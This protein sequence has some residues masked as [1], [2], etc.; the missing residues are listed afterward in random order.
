LGGLFP[1][2]ARLT[3]SNRK[4]PVMK[5]DIVNGPGRRRKRVSTRVVELGNNEVMNDP[6]TPFIGRNFRCGL[7]KKEKD[8]GEMTIVGTV[9]MFNESEASD[10]NRLKVKNFKESQERDRCYLKES[11]KTMRVIQKRSKKMSMLHNSLYRMNEGKKDVSV[12]VES[13]KDD[14]WLKKKLDHS[15]ILV[16]DSQPANHGWSK[17][18]DELSSMDQGLDTSELMLN[19]EKIKVDNAESSGNKFYV[20]QAYLINSLYRVEDM[21]MANHNMNYGDIKSQIKQKFSVKSPRTVSISKIDKLVSRDNISGSQ[22]GDD[23]RLTA[24]IDQD[25]SSM[26]P[27]LKLG[28]NL[29]TTLQMQENTSGKYSKNRSHVSIGGRSTKLENSK[30]GVS[31]T[32]MTVFQHDETRHNSNSHVGPDRRRDCGK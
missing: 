5:T 28:R 14:E 30:G 7:I 23:S 24:A 31:M 27:S 17:A 32:N 20:D 3:V 19:L 21:S 12:L 15:S 26:P 29:N 1:S 18:V 4:V 6:F 16:G 9:K 8:A 22:L 2:G 25:L 13:P 11:I 10:E